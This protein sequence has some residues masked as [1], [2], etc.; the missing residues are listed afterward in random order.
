[1]KKHY[2]LF[3]A[4][5]I[6][7]VFFAQTDLARWNNSNQSGTNYSTNNIT[8]TDLKAV[9]VTNTIQSNF[10]YNN[11]NNNIFQS[12]NWPTTQ[13]VN[14]DLNKYIQFTISPKAGYKLNLSEFNFSCGAYG[15]GTLKVDYSIKSDFSNP[16]TI[17]QPTVI[18]SPMSNYS[19]KGFLTPLAT[20]GQVVYVR[21]YFY[22]TDQTFQILFQE[23]KNVGPVF[24]GTVTSSSTTPIATNDNVT[25]YIND[26]S[27]INVLANDD[28]SNTVNSIVYSQPLHGTAT[29]NADHT[30]TYLPTKG[31]KGTDSFT[32]KIIN[33]F[34]ESNVATV[35]INVV[36]NTS[37]TLIRW[38]KSDYNSTT[39]QTFINPT[40]MTVAGGV[41]RTTGNE[42]T[43]IYIFGNISNSIIDTSKYIQFV[44]D[45]L[46][47]EKTLELKKFSFTG[48][49]YNS[50]NYQV[51]YSKTNDFS[52]EE[53]TIGS[54]TLPTSF[55]TQ[56]IN[57]DTNAK[58]EPKEKIYIRLY[59][60]NNVSQYIIN[61]RTGD[62]GPQVEGLFYNKVYSVNETIWQN[63]TWSNGVPTA[64]KSAVINTNYD[65][66]VNGNFTSNNLTINTGATLTV[67]TGGFISVNGQITNNN[68]AAGSFAIEHD[69]N[70]LQTGNAINTGN[71]TVRKSAIIPKMG[72]NYWSSPVLNQNLYQFS[73]G[74]NQANG[75]TGNGTPWNRFYVY[76]EANDYFVTSIANDITLNSTSVF[77]PARG[78]AIRGK[79]SFPATVTVTSPVSKFEFVG[80]PQNGD[81]ATYNLKWSDDKHGYNM[82]G[83]P[84]PSNINFDEFFAKNSTKIYGVGY[85]WTNND[86]RI[87]TQQSSS[88]NGNNYAIATV[89][90]GTSA[91]YY[92]INNRKP[93]GNISVGQGFIVQA[94]P[95]GKDKPLVFTNS[96]RNS[97]IANYY[98]KSNA[99]KNRFWLEF[100]SPSDINN[101]ILI[102][103]IANATNDY[104]SDY[105]AD[106]L[107]IG[108]DSFWSVLDNHKLAIQAKDENFSIEDVAKL[109]FK[110]SVAGDYT[111]TLREKNGIFN[112]NQSVYLKDKYQNKVINITDSG[113]KFYTG[114]GQY[115]DRFEVIYK[116]LETLSTD[117]VSKKGI[118]IS[119]DTENFVVKSGDDL[120]EV[121]L[122]DSIGR[123]LFSTKNAKKEVLINKTNLAEGMYIIKVNSRNAAMTKKVLK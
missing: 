48:R 87:L 7:N 30:I 90:G 100:K 51:K 38:D 82:V 58:A 23:G 63:S 47:A 25:T 39:S 112:S 108:N 66:A 85:F 13:Q 70:L 105:D 46:S 6:A 19:L 18:N 1:M 84:Y 77:Q 111:I 14:L 117:N 74:Y 52:G 53:V 78:Y 11:T 42:N 55:Q 45:N 75:G 76:N 123:L 29:L 115:E 56:T 4:I 31:Y 83:N 54:G 65:T 99:E 20:D 95:E 102:G 3:F 71:A 41:T 40:L 28:Y 118:I 5:L 69:G 68:T 97:D 2:F 72:Y 88:Y 27:N 101:E 61:Y 16:V 43:P 79:N 114:A 103:Y 35:N 107:A 44:V 57:F 121:S 37:S 60:Y 32:Y 110:A 80:V 93:N 8:V 67:N 116:S 113:Y 92:G 120:D 10:W 96:M 122:Y 36:E 109:G 98:N 9:G 21:V 49:G 17:M 81:V 89:I 64:T 59:L 26:D 94:K 91:T 24:R 106:L 15:P 34:G 50:G 119:K 73:D 22:N 62:L 12:G 104:D 33:N 86:G